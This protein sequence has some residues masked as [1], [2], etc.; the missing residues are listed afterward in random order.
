MLDRFKCT[1]RTLMEMAN[2][3]WNVESSNTMIRGQS[4]RYKAMIEAIETATPCP[5]ATHKYRGC[6]VDM[7][8][9]GKSRQRKDFFMHADRQRNRG[10]VQTSPIDEICSIRS[11]ANLNVWGSVINCVASPS[12][13]LIEQRLHK[14]SD[15]NKPTHTQHACACKTV[16]QQVK[17]KKVSFPLIQ[18][19]VI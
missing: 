2:A 11:S 12:F 3:I 1:W 6:Y 8:E 19:I 14:T 13:V 9:T 4:Y 16:V 10:S 15:R 5:I 7:F 17:R 18:R